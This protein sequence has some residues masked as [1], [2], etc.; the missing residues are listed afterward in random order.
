MCGRGWRLGGG[1]STC[2]VLVCQSV[3]VNKTKEEWRNFDFILYVRSICLT[4]T[5]ARPSGSCGPQ[6][7]YKP[8]AVAAKNVPKPLP[9]ALAVARAESKLRDKL[10]CSSL[11]G[12]SC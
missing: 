11:L 5:Q 3:N 9:F 1:L 12:E 8:D 6:D 2:I 4:A 7:D 10:L